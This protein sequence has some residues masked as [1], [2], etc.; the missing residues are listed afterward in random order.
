MKE[1][2]AY[3]NLYLENIEGEIWKYL[4]EF[5]NRYQISNMG[6]IKSFCNSKEKILKQRVNGSGYCVIGINKDAK[7]YMFKMN[8]L[9]AKNFIF[10]TENKKTVNHKK[11]IKTD[12]RAS[13]LEWMTQGENNLHSI[14]NNLKKIPNK[15]KTIQMDMDY[16]IIKIWDSCRLAARELGLKNQNISLV[17]L[18]I[19]NSCGGFRWKYSK[20]D[21][22]EE[23]HIE[24]EIWMPING[25]EGLYEVSNFGR[26]KSLRKNII[27]SLNNNGEYS[28]VNLSKDT[29]QKNKLVHILVAEAFISNPENKKFINH[30]KGNKKDN[31]ATELEWMTQVEN[32][33]HSYDT[34]LARVNR[35]ESNGSSKLTEKDVI[36]I[37]ELHFK[38]SSR[39]IGEIFNVCHSTI[40]DVIN[41]KT[42][43]EN[44]KPQ[45]SELNYN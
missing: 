20:I 35:G 31:R 44:I 37:R 41:N 9:V 38:L 27:L 11:G 16:N 2:P 45:F 42:W 3:K 15:K 24:G 23:K 14:K 30:K 18:G 32:N 39:K 40:L 12:N 22:V 6:R 21:S 8:I 19:W 7:K 34:G 5:E 13:E 29:K 28:R 26:I 43:N 1:I 36:K 10:N 25:Y 4:A 17:A 33:K